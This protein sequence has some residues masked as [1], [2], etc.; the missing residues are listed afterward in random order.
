MMPVALVSI[1][2]SLST[3]YPHVFQEQLPPEHLECKPRNPDVTI[4]YLIAEPTALRA[5]YR[6]TSKVVEQMQPLRTLRILKTA[7]DKWVQ[8]GWRDPG[9][10][11]DG[12]LRCGWLETRTPLKDDPNVLGSDLLKILSIGLELDKKTWPIA[13]KADILRGRPR[14]GFTFEQVQLAVGRPISVFERETP[15]GT[16]EVWS[17]PTRSVVFAG[18]KVLQID[19]VRWC[20]SPGAGSP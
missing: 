10:G 19:T 11:A 6:P 20:P 18:G 8:L 1:F 16:M 17:Y 3:A 7:D 9:S 12:P 5:E 4:M 13:V 2:L 15:S 14:V